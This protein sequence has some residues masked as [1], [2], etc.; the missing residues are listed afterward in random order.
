MSHLGRRIEVI[1]IDDADGV[2]VSE[3]LSGGGVQSFTLDGALIV[4]GEFIN[5]ENPHKILFTFAADETGRTFTIIGEDSRGVSITEAVA[6]A[7]ATA[8]SVQLFSKI[9]DIQ[10]DAN[11]AGAVTIG[12][13]AFC[14]TRWIPFHSYDEN[15]EIGMSVALSVS[16]DL[17]YVIE[18]TSL[19]IQDE[20]LN[21]DED[22]NLFVNEGI[23]TFRDA[24]A[25]NDPNIKDAY[26][27]F[28]PLS[29]YR[30]RTTEFVTGTVTF[31]TFQQRI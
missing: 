23:K 16:A 10:S 27:Y 8:L 1:P 31:S 14:T 25:G 20:S 29:A 2:V 5:T 3:T 17:R 15:S 28:A 26:N 6:G 4:N 9:T 12:T 13:N 30:F 18:H 7:A 19:D 24:N 22:I 21:L 11:T